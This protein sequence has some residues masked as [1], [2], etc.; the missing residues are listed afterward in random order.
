MEPDCVIDTKGVWK[1]FRIAQEKRTTFKEHMISLIRG[2]SYDY[3]EFW[4]L[5]D[6]SFSIERG[7]CLGII[8]PNGS[9]KTTL[10]SIL[11]NVLRLDRGHVEI[12]GRVASFL[13]LGIGFEPDLTAKENVYL[14]GSIMGLRRR[15]LDRKID[16]IFEFAELDRFRHM[17]LKNFSSGMYLRLAFSTAITVD[18]DIFLIDEA[19][20]VGDMAFQEKCKERIRKFKEDGRTIIFV[21]HDL[22]AVKDI[23]ER[24]VFLCDSEIWSIGATE[25]VINDYQ[26][27]SRQR[28]E[29]K[30]ISE[31]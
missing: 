21:S 30:K 24:S 26:D 5:K 1:H 27:Y 23:C 14:Y 31:E 20:A 2:E 8:G 10:L 9:G 3:E 19:L 6:V 22:A 7:E 16:D 4:A 13:G 29:I 15:E 11:A 25:H 28:S 18:P 12:R 17:R